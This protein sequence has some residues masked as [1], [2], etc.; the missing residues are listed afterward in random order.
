MA[1]S[2]Q[3][4]ETE[5]AE[6]KD[7][8]TSAKSIVFTSYKGL[9]VEKMQGLRR[10]LKKSGAALLACK[11]SL[12]KTAWSDAPAEVNPLQLPGSMAL[13]FGLEDEVSPAKILA[14]FQKETNDALKIQGGF[15]N[16]SFL[17]TGKIMELASLPSRLELLAKTVGTIKAPVTG[18]VNVLSGN[19]R[20]LVNALNAISAKGATPAG[21]LGFASGEKE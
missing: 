9:S 11:K 17:A 12:L 19:L 21:G 3:Q 20:G 15:L 1:K 7:Y 5:V 18:L 2:R 8:L 14:A 4:K 13:A 10:R 6:L 16:N